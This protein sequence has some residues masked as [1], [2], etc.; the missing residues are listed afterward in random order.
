MARTLL[1]V[2]KVGAALRMTK[3]HLLP[4]EMSGSGQFEK[5]LPTNQHGRCAFS[6]GRMVR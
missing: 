2:M 4:P 3:L 6:S 1:V 5:M